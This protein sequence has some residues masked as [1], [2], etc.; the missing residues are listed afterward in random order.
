MARSYAQ[1]SFCGKLASAVEEQKPSPHEHAL[2]PCSLCKREWK[3]MLFSY[4]GEGVGIRLFIG[5]HNGHVEY[6]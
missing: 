3:E 5:V 2:L 6:P 1:G 4:I